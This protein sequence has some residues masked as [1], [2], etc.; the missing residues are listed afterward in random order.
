MWNSIMGI[1]SFII[2][3]LSFN[4][5]HFSTDNIMFTLALA[6]CCYHKSVPTGLYFRDDL[7]VVDVIPHR[8]NPERILS[9]ASRNIKK[10][11]IPKKGS[12]SNL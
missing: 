9:N 8:K 2:L 4:P 3:A 1:V 11:P 7:I 10:V 12:S 6:I 5:L